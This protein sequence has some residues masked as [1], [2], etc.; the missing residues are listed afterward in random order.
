MKVH[1]LIVP[2]VGSLFA[3]ALNTNVWAQNSGALEEIV[4]TAQK[5]SESLQ[6]VPISISV[7]SE[8]DIERLNISNTID[9]VKNIP[10]MTGVTN[11][12]LPQAAAYFIRG[13]GQDES[14]ATL[15]P[16]VGTFVDGV[17]VSRQIANNSRLY[18]IESV[19]VLKGPQGTLYGRN[20]TGGAVRI[21]TQKP[22]EQTEGWFDIAYG[23]YQTI[24]MSGKVNFPLTDKAFAKVTMLKLDIDDY[25]RS[26]I[27]GTYGGIT[28][29]EAEQVLEGYKTELK[30]WNYITELI[31]KQ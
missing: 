2:I 26:L 4:V 28:Y 6:E 5:R 7:F 10:G 30:V 18:D 9:L 22:T 17:F 29:E 15:D 19:E 14:V 3:I 21:I 12:G 23:E 20:T 31:E 27:D 25:K 24:E 11:V 8:D 1:K 16:A 13:I